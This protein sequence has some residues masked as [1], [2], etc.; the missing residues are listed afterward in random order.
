MKGA[1]RV[2]GLTG[3][4]LSVL[5]TGCAGLS[6]PDGDALAA[7]QQR[8]E[9]VASLKGWRMQGRI[10]MQRDG[11]GGQLRVS[12]SAFADGGHR[13]QVRNTFGQT[14]MVLATTESGP[15]L[16]DARG[17]TYTGEAARAELERRLGGRV[18]LDRFARWAGG[19]GPADSPPSAVDDRGRPGAVASGPW[20]VTYGDY[21]RVEGIWLP[22][23][24]TV[25]YIGFQMRLLV[26]RWSLRWS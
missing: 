26:D 12:L 3:L 1:G 20:S 16:R 15:V 25:Q 21:R 4:A 8:A 22:S 19:V 9:Q 2:A 6:G 14:V 13:L 24:V 7:Y 17:R 18:P 5:L 23:Q 11:E 10:A